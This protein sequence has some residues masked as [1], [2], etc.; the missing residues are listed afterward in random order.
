MFVD[1]DGY[2]IAS[3][4]SSTGWSGFGDGT[5]L[6]TDTY[7]YIKGNASV[8]FDISSAGGTTA[9]VVN[10]TLATY[11][12]TNFKSNGSV[13]AWVYITST[14]NLTNY[15]VRLGSDSSNYYSMTATTTNEGTAF[16]TGWNLLRFDF[17]GKS[18]TGT[19]VDASC[20]YAAIYMTKTAGKVSETDYRFDHLIVKLG[21][22]YDFIYYSKYPWQSSA[23]TYKQ[24]STD[25]TD[26]INADE[27]EYGIILEKCVELAAREIREDAD[28]VTAKNNFRDMVRDY[29][30][31]YRSEAVQSQ[32][33][34]YNF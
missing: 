16:A 2:T 7:E 26:Y 12:L 28:M 9:G 1:D 25:D 24:N 14:T 17:S 33:T 3:L 34:Y 18:T 20:D 21:A 15:I 23:G 10:S 27:D 4:D 5:N 8:K 6:S 29:R 13:F 32:N 22:I 11:D 30:R 19:P 31:N